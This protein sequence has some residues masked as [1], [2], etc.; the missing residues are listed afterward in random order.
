MSNKRKVIIWGY[1]SSKHTHYYTHEALR[2]A[3]DFCG[4]ETHFFDNDNNP[5][6]FDYSNSIFFTEGFADHKIPLRKDCVYFVHVCVNPEKYLNAEVKKLIDVRYLMNYM[7]DDNYNFTLDRKS[8]EVLDEGVLLERNS[9][10]PYE[11]IYMAWATNLLPQEINLEWA[12]QKRENTYY[13]AG[14]ISQSGRFANMPMISEFVS[15][16]RKN[17]IGFTFVDPWTN[18]VSEEEHRVLIRKS[19]LSPDFRNKQHK[20]WGY[21]AC[22]LMKSISFGQI[23]I[24]NCKTNANFLDESIIYDENPSNLFYL[25]K[26]K[27]GDVKLIQHQ[28]NLIKE[29]HTFVN[30]VKGIEKIL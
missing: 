22:R 2:K 12:K 18:P 23:G 8:C 5:E 4:Y 30:R 26:E 29:K 13:F 7:D 1:S 14:S 9:A 10:Q 28:M 21:I 25:G 15:E 19:Y 24:T 6:N 16:C 27:M 3:F 20:E 11:I 17:E